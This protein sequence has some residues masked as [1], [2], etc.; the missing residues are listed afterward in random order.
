MQ[1]VLTAENEPSPEIIVRAGN[2]N[3]SIQNEFV[4]KVTIQ[5]T[6]DSIAWFDVEEFS[7]PGEYYGTEG[8][9]SIYRAIIKSGNYTSGSIFVRI[10]V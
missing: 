3:L 5:R 4:A 2:F 6:F 9:G 8:E 7:S 10:G 1:V